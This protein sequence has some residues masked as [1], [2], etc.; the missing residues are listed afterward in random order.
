VL[1]VTVHETARV[2]AAA[3]DGEVLVTQVT[4]DL[5]GGSGLDFEDRGEHVL[6]GFDEAR[7]LF[8]VVGVRSPLGVPVT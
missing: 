8:A 5:A 4:R 7:R 2:A 1:G 6:R 3:A